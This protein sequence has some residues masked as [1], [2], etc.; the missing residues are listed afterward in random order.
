[1][2]LSVHFRRDAPGTA[3]EKAGK[4]ADLGM[5]GAFIHTE[6]P[7]A[8]GAR[9]LVTLAAPTAWDPLEL[10]AEVRWLGRDGEPGFGARFVSLSAPQAAALYALLAAAGYEP[11]HEASP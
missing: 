3:F 7:P 6:R 9:I 11:D 10:P 5:G 2:E 1:M 8:I 4:V